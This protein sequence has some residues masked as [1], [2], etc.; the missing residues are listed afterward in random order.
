VRLRARL[1]RVQVQVSVEQR[2]LYLLA[3]D[4]VV[5]PF[6]AVG[7]VTEEHEALFAGALVRQIVYVTALDYS[8]Q[9]FSL[10]AFPGAAYARSGSLPSTCS[11]FRN[12]TNGS[13]FR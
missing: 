5:V 10:S 7:Q 9:Y 1:L 6:V 8:H 4:A 12:V 11:F 2:A 13:V 3:Q